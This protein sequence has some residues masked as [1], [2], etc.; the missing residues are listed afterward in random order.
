MA[1]YTILPS[2]LC[3][4]RIATANTESW[5]KSQLRKRQSSTME[6]HRPEAVPFQWS[7]LE[8]MYRPTFRQTCDLISPL[9]RTGK[10]EE[11]HSSWVHQ[12]QSRWCKELPLNL[13][14]KTTAVIKP[15]EALETTRHLLSPGGGNNSTNLKIWEKK[16]KTLHGCFQK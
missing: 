15:L 1:K 11:L 6:G 4:G 5:N 7:I 3:I 12:S 8:E 2:H 16:T 10:T 14:L 13:C 9:I